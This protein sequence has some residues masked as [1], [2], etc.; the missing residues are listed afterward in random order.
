MSE[1]YLKQELYARIRTDP[2]VFEFLQAGSLD[3]IWYWDLENPEHEWYSPRF[4]E[5]LGY[6]HHE[7]PSSSQW[8]Q[9]HIF[10]EDLEVARN[11][12]EHHL[13]DPR[14]P[15]DQIVRYRH[16]DGST[17]W[18]RCRGVALRN[19]SGKPVRM[20][21]AHTDVTTLK[22]AELVEHQKQEL[23]DFNRLMVGRENR[24][25]ELKK[26]VNSLS[27]ELGRRPPYDLS[28]IDEDPE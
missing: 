10:P 9:T 20:L 27:R 17:V 24:I 18:V 14:H 26:Q 4:A 3:G 2:E 25:I 6:A 12:F 16:K 22:K 8:W 21:G 19:K 5:G 15:Y 23:M 1:H 13:H 28:G 7:I 11:N